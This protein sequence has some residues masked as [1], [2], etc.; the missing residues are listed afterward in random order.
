MATQALFYERATPLSPQRHGSWCVDTTPSYDFSRHVNSVPLTSIEMPHAAR[1]YTIAFAGAG[2]DVIPVV[3]LG[4][5]GNENLYV[6]EQGGWDAHY[7]PAF[8]RRYPFVFS[9]S[10]D[11]QT[12]T[13][14][15]D[16]GWSG[17]NQEGRGERLFTEEGKPTPYTEKML[18]FVREYQ[19]QVQRTQAYCSKLQELAL[20]EPRQVN[21]TAGDGPQKTMG[22]FMVASRDKLKA[23]PAQTLWEFA[24]NDEL[25]LTYT[26]L[27][28]MNNISLV[29][30]RVV[31][32]RLQAAAP[33][34]D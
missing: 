5:E 6:T 20:L 34:A 23:L 4:I 7:I 31:K 13:L 24:Q 3:L 15:I 33:A 32:R 19:R 28:S 22:G 14:C 30:E 2:R 26:H 11:G 8:V 17:C 27:Q 25:E 18:G 9:Q 12:F 1:E 21:F 16:E 10:P 29:L